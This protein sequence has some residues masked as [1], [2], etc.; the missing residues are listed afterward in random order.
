MCN[1]M[2]ASHKETATL[3]TTSCAINI[4]YDYC[5]NFSGALVP[6]YCIGLD[7]LIVVHSYRQGKRITEL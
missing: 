7:K 4:G 6:S 5:P 1:H 3:N 2:T